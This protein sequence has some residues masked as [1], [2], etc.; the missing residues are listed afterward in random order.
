M[1]FTTITLI[2]VMLAFG[3]GDAVAEKR[4]GKKAKVTKLTA[5]GPTLRYEQFRQKIEFKVA[6]KREEQINGIKRL[7][8]LGPAI[9]EVPDL[10]FRLAELYFEKARFYFFRAQ[11]ADDKATRS[12]SP[13]EKSS[14]E[15]EQKK[16]TQ[17]SKAWQARAVELYREIRDRFPKYKRMPEVLFAL[18][19]SYWSDG[20]FQAAIEVYADLIR[21]FKDSPLIPEAWIAFGEFYFNEGDVNKAL[22]SYEK[23]ALDKRSRV[24]GFA[25]YKQAWCYYN[26]SKWEEALKK[27]KATIL[28]SQL[29]QELSGEN[30]IALG[31][32]AQKDYVRTYRHV[33]D[34]KRA[35]FIF[36]D[37][38]GDDNCTSKDCQGMLELLADLWTE[39]GYFDEAAMLYKQLISLNPKNTRN[40][41]FEGKIVDLVSRSQ[42]KK[43]TIRETRELVALYQ[44]GKEYIATLTGKSESEEQGR[45]NI[46]EAET[47]AE[48][49]IRRLG[50]L[51]NKEAIKLRQKDT[52]EDARTM[53]EM[54]LQLFPQSKYAYEM[55]FQLG[56]LYYKL[57]KFDDAARMYEATVMAA[58]GTPPQTQYLVDAA[59]DNILA[60]EE[61]IKDL[62]LKKPKPADKPIP[63]PKEK[64]RLIE[65]CDRYI[66]LVPA[67]KA[68]KLVSVKANAAK[69]L[70]DYSH[71]EEALKRFDEIV[72]QHPASQEAE[73]AA[74]LV[75]DIYHQRKD[76]EKLYD[77]AAEYVKI[78][79]LMKGRDQLAH[80]LAHF[81]EYAKFA[82][83]QI[84]EERV[85][86]EHGDIKLV[87]EGY[88][89]FYEEFPK[90]DNADK[91]LFNASVAW[92]KVGQKDKADQLRKK[93]LDEYPK[94]PLG[95]DVA[96]YIAKRY[97]ERTE[98]GKAAAE[99]LEFAKR[100]P[101]DERARDAMFNA[102]VFYAGI[103]SVKKANDLRL[104]YLKLYGKAKGGEKEAAEIYWTIAQ[105][106]DRSGR[107][108]EASRRY[109][110]YAK[111]FGDTEHFWDA[112]WREAEI[113]RKKLRAIS[114]ADKI[115]DEILGTYHYRKKRS[116]DVPANAARYASL[117][118]FKK[119]DKD[120]KEYAR[121]RIPT[122]NLKNPTQF[123]RAL[124]DKAQWRERMIKSYT[125][126]VTDYQQAESTIASLYKI[127]V[128][129]DEFVAKVT[130]VACPRG[131]PDEAC[132]IIK[133]EMDTMAA[134]AREAAYAAY[135]TCVGKSNE[136]NTFTN[137]ST[138]C[139]KKLERLAPA[140]FPPITEKAM[141]YKAG[142]RLEALEANTL[143]LDY[144]GYEAVQ[145]QYETVQARNTEQE[146]KKDPEEPR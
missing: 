61:F 18:G 126:V 13:G 4:R 66:A 14:L 104:D 98:Y 24:Y 62:R 15:A 130:S 112:M 102:A 109:E 51:W 71:N 39:D 74:N 86:K 59:N 27:F 118:A 87:A 28:Y 136:L 93:L 64:Q 129:W 138:K 19:Q 45:A 33:G 115:E 121:M 91:A 6:E 96:Y 40:P 35:R 49:T 60:L 54:Y 76:W 17:E 10:K 52:Y 125:R 73:V 117:V 90:S 143:I 22:K 67:D 9:E 25:L 140:E 128:A 43:R 84:L 83:V 145:Q 29:A 146:K 116:K 108:G 95:V 122:P 5:G 8:E 58:K 65:A 32:E 23:A 105:D 68:E 34:P 135:R 80:D 16:N 119:I 114:K 72:H 88:Q 46:A 141:E 139:V 100:Y 12:K 124:A 42:D 101:S 2:A 37:L 38:V 111:Q 120:W 132:Q 127:A 92:D 21:N 53:Y 97:E 82:L 36:A 133:Q 69:L 106:L 144:A 41:L 7:I 134:P 123:K 57:E 110:E 85:N 55:R 70:Y 79:D 44:K 47:I 103:G 142:A 94:S 77:H 78:P 56:D 50:Q 11:E 81:M 113:C 3:A 1:R 31:R 48:T 30:K 26:L 89:S 131:I 107:F 75:I 20:Q 137:Y 63:L 99:F